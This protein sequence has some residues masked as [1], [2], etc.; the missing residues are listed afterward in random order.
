[1]EKIATFTQVEDLTTRGLGVNPDAASLVYAAPRIRASVPG[2]NWAGTIGGAKAVVRFPESSRWNGKLLIGGI[3]A[4]RTEYSLDL[5][6]SD[7]ALQRGYAFA[8]CDKGTPGLTLRDPTRSMV[9]WA[10]IY[11]ELTETVRSWVGQIYGRSPQRTY[12]AG[13][14]NGGYVTRIMMEQYPELFDGAV[15][16]EGVFWHPEARHLMTDLPVFV[17]D[18]PIHANWRGDRTISEQNSALARLLEAGLHPDSAPHWETYFFTYWVVSLWLYG[19]SL[20]PEW[21]PFAEEWSNE[22]LKNPQAI[23]DYPWQQR[24]DILNN[25]ITPIANNGQIRKPM[26]SV[27]GN[28]DCLVPFEHN[29]RAYANLVSRQGC[30]EQ[31]RLYEIDRGNHVDGMVNPDTSRQQLVQPYFEAALWHL[32]DWVEKG[33]QPPAGGTFHRIEDFTSQYEQLLSVLPTPSGRS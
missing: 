17:R 26:L 31:H 2:Q 30:G 5:I 9:E 23:A 22:W 4:V 12:I 21:K 28:W 8:A 32:E 1:M 7:I 15:E 20:D 6:L 10:Q 29:A 3:P 18:Y 25:R 19:R 27:A 13:L 11:S 16:W 24:S 14:S 33:V